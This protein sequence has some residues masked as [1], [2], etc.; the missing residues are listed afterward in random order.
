MRLN[1]RMLWLGDEALGEGAGEGERL[2]EAAVV[3]TE[4]G[5][6]SAAGAWLPS[7]AM[8]AVIMAPGGSESAMTGAG[9]M[10][11]LSATSTITL[12]S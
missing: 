12:G 5:E 4:A 3:D 2:V 11:L 8:T 7:G 10:G 9:M 1:E 6:R